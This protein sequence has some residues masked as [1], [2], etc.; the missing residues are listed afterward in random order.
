MAKGI[1]PESIPPSVARVLRGPGPIGQLVRRARK[2]LRRVATELGG[3]AVDVVFHAGYEPP[4]SQIVDH[5]RAAKVLDHVLSEGWLSPGRVKVPPPLS[6][7]ALRRVHDDAYLESLDAPLAVARALGGE[8]PPPVSVAEGYLSAQRWATAGTVHAAHLARKRSGVAL[9]LGGGFHH[10]ERA[11]GGGF[12][13]FHDVAVAIEDL[14]AKGFAGRILVLD[15][16]LHQGDGT[17]RIFREDASVTAASVHATAWAE[18][19]APYAIDIALGSGVGDAT[20]LEAVHE[21]IDLAV[22]RGEP[23]MVFYVAGVDI[24]IDDTLGS[25]RVSAE[26]IA[27][28]DRIV[29]E[30]FKGRPLVMVLAGGYGAEAWRHTARTLVWLLSGE[31]RV[32][33]T[34]QDRELRQF[35]RVARSFGDED[36]S[37]KQGDGD[38]F[39]ITEA[40][41]LGDLVN[42]RPRDL[43]LGYYTAYGLELAFERYGMFDVL[44]K[45]G[46]RQF[47]LELNPHAGSG[48]AVTV[49][50]DDARRLVL[51]EL[52]VRE[53]REVVPWRLLSIEW[54]LLQDPLGR[55]T[56]E[57][58]LLPGQDHPGLGGLKIMTGMLAMAAERL[59]FDGLTFVPAHY[60]TAAQARATLRFLDPRDEALFVAMKEAMGARSLLEA[61]H[62]L[63]GGGLVDETTGE[64]VS[65]KPAR[66]V[67]PASDA[68]KAAVGSDAYDRKVE[69]A[70]QELK[71]RLADDAEERVEAAARAAAMAPV[72]ARPPGLGSASGR[73]PGLGPSSSGRPPASGRGAGG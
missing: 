42:K 57:R 25:W 24:A 37:R 71:L 54:L 11:R 52:V 39:G 16:D 64:R 73:P 56:A 5:R 2:G 6:L 32:I 67:V 23:E 9:N 3:T 72:S 48:E 59:G 69:A 4:D 18:E 13:L 21:V 14:R 38:N 22:T 58:P 60:H 49:R 8:E 45:R 55:P 44:R 20:Y 51:I 30:R 63:N 62:L 15:L 35:R 27:E 34:A 65:W 46:Y 33:P 10:A 47:R 7:A 66:M 61:T 19:E 68:L 28:R 29:L 50:T 12:C 53:M 41:L 43:L 1:L 36:L 26:T 40:D 17:R 70:A 31:D